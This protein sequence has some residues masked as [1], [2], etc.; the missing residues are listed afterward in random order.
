[1]KFY[2]SFF[3]VFISVLSYSQVEEEW[4]FD[5]DSI[6]ISGTLLVPSEDFDG[7]V[8]LFFS[9]SG[10]TD[11]NGNTGEQFQNNSLKMLAE[12]LAENGVA[13]LRFDKRSIPMIAAGRVG[14][15]MSFDYFVEDGLTWLE[16][17]KAD[18]RFKEYYVLGH[19]Q[20]STVGALVAKDSS[21]SKLI[22]SWVEFS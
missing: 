18:K 17:L 11:R 16:K 10:V 5:V 13:S 2:L 3:A 22:A 1:M 21:V 4:T 19:S 20:G 14:A 12:G 9:G 7:P 6:T 8:V 15:D